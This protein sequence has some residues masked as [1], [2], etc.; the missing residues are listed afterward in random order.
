MNRKELIVEIAEES[1]LK[2]REVGK[3]L[4]AFSKTVTESL[5][6]GEKVTISGFGSFVISQRRTARFRPSK[7][8]KIQIR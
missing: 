2:K 8:L 6:K 5:T 3:L 4:T 7:K 1:G